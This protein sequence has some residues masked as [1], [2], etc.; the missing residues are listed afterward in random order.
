MGDMKTSN[1][2]ILIWGDCHLARMHA[3][4]TSITTLSNQPAARHCS[5]LVRHSACAVLAANFAISKTL[6][7]SQ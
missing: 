6:H 2:K 4:V 1:P 7:Q 3:A 5:L